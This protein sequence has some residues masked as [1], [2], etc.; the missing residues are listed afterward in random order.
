MQLL[1]KPTEQKRIQ[2]KSILMLLTMLRH[3][4]YQESC[5]LGLLNTV[6]W[7]SKVG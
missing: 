6:F 7:S 1:S 4:F 5:S 2:K 3:A